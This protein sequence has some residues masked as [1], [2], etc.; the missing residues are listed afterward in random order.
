MSQP[1]TGFHQQLS[2]PFDFPVYFQR[3]TFSSYNPL[4]VNTI[5]RLH[6]KRRHRVFVCVD[7]GAARA[8]PQCDA[9][10]NKYFKAHQNT[11]ELAGPIEHTKGGEQAKQHLSSL[12]RMIELMAK[13]HLARQS[14]VLIIGGGGL[15]DMVGLASS[16]IHRGL[17]VIRMPTTV[18]GQND[19]GVGVK[20]GIDLFNLSL[21]H[22]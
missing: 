2:I 16:L 7:E 12:T 20:T 19:V 15:L 3:Q 1:I 21:I 4:L 13:R 6:E 5:D 11:L 18:V 10:I 17:R 8:W 22:I 14:V 9:Q